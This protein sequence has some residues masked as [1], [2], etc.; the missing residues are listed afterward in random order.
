MN[1]RE[2]ACK[3]RS[4]PIA[5][6]HKSGRFVREVPKSDNVMQH[7]WHNKKD[8]REAV[9]PS[10]QAEKPITRRW[11]VQLNSICA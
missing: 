9:S 3:V 4:T 6:K 7:D 11:I 8:R 2:M 1:G 5:D 10:D